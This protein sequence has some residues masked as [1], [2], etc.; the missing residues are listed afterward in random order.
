M[1]WPNYSKIHSNRQPITFEP[2]GAVAKLL[3]HPVS[4]RE[5]V[6]SILCRVI[7]KAFKMVLATL[8]FALS[9]EKVEL[10]CPGQYTNI[11]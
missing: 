11:M 4:V 1:R 10:V 2:T 5:V 8:S 3:E 7:P 6:G 9:I